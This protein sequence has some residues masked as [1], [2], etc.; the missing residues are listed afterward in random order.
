MINMQLN[1]PFYYVIK[2]L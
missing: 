1:L 2:N